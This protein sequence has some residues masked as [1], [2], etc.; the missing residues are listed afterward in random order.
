MSIIKWTLCER[1]KQQAACRSPLFAAE[2]FDP[3]LMWDVAAEAHS[4]AAADAAS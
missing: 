4:R 2:T 3:R 1:N